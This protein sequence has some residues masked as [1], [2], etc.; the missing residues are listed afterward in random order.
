MRACGAEKRRR[1]RELEL[2]GGEGR[3]GDEQGR[4]ACREQ[5]LR[6]PTPLQGRG[7]C[8]GRAEQFEVRCRPTPKMGHGDRRWGRDEDDLGSGEQSTRSSA[9][10]ELDVSW[11][12][13]GAS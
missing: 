13:T 6:R 7:R 12:S 5:V 2:Q 4:P 8:P 11:V 9:T 1:Q 3:H 10:G